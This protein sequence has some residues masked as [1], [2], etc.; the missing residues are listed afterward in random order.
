MAHMLNVACVQNCATDDLT[1]NLAELNDLI[2]QAA[3]DGAD[4]V[5]LP[6]ACEF[7]SGDNLAMKAH[8]TPLAEHH[9]FQFLRDCAAHHGIW[10]LIGSLTTRDDAGSMVNRSLLVD[11][12][13]D[14]AASYDKIHMFDAKVPGQ[15]MER[16][17]DLYRPGGTA[18]LA[19]LPGAVLG[20]SICYDVRFPHLYRSLAK[21]GATI[22][23]VPAAFMQA[24]GEAHWH[25]LLRARA[26]EN[27][28][29]V[30]APAQTGYHYGTRYS[31]GHSLIVDPWGRVVADAGAKVGTVHAQINLEDISWARSS[32]MSLNHDRI[33]EPPSPKHAQDV[34]KE[35]GM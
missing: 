15:K 35:F 14:L 34:S 18:Q 21:A 25:A 31:F 33:F 17:S 22:L 30:I 16:E 32:I 10:L 24:T 3:R 13:G 11:P 2:S 20:M 9:A 27:G 7:L 23:S 19:A 1:A 5:A 6:E 26:I 29:F 12:K 4:I 28:C 8:A